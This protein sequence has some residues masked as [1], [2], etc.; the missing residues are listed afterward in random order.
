MKQVLQ[1]LHALSLHN[2]KA[3]FDAH[4]AE[5]ERAKRTITD[6]AIDLIG[7]I[8]AFDDSIGPLSVTDC[9]FRI[10]RD[11]RFSKDKSPYKTHMGVFV[12]RGGRK[13]GYSGYYFHIDGKGGHFLAIGNYYTE[14]PVLKVLREDIEMSNGDFRKII[15]SV[16][17]G[18]ILDTE[19]ALKKVPKGFPVD[20]PDSELFKLKNYCLLKSVDEDFILAPDLADRLVRNFQT[21]KPF[22]DF[23][24]RAIDYCREE[25]REYFTS[26]E[27]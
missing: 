7:G 25:K 8:R 13:S 22:L 14:P 24:N 9:T 16:A 17:P 10:Y 18:F 12:V 26:F 6:L 5:Y 27:Y 19:G 21:G 11:V 4:K 23:I 2:D 3:W 20:S 15:D 1:Y